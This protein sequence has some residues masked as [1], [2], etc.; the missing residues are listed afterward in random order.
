[1][2]EYTEIR[3]TTLVSTRIGLGTWA[4]GSWMFH[5]NHTNS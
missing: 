3:D 2:L 4:V 1:M 5:G